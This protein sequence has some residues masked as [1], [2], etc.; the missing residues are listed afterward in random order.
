[1][2]LMNFWPLSDAIAKTPLPHL[3]KLAT[4]YRT[5]RSVG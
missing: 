1:L 3:Q 5:I 2:R 4:R